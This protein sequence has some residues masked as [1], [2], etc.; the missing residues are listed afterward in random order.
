[1]GWGSTHADVDEG[2][3]RH[4]VTHGTGQTSARG[5]IAQLRHRRT[6]QRRRN[7]GAR[8]AA[9]RRDG[10]QQ[11]RQCRLPHPH[12]L[13]HLHIRFFPQAAHAGSLSGATALVC[14][15]VAFKV[16]AGLV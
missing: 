11:V 7:V 1:V 15:L 9:G 2:S 16:R 3:E 14:V 4:D 5:E 6:Q 13:C 8:V 12:R 10:T